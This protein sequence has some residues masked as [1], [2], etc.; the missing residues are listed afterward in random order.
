MKLPNEKDRKGILERVSAKAKILETAV[1]SVVEGYTPA[2]FV[3]GKP[4]LGKT[5]LLTTI[6]DGLC[7]QGWKHHTAYSTP[8]ALFMTLA[9]MPNAVH[10]YE[11]CEPILKTEKTA[12]ILR[13][14]CGAPGDR[15]RLV[16]YETANEK[17]RIKFYGGIIIA[18]N[19]DLSRA[20]GPLQGVASR[21]RPMTWALSMEERVATISLLADQ[22]C[23]RG[24]MALSPKECKEVAV[25]LL[26]W[27]DAG[28]DP[29]S[30]DLRLYCEH[31]L[32][33]FAYCKAKG[34]KNWS[35]VL[36]SK[37]S[38]IA[39]TV[40]ERQHERTGRLEDLAVMIDQGTGSRTAKLADWTAKTGLGKSIYY[41]HLKNAKRGR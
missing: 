7:G 16:T 24:K 3:C 12:S 40:C 13:A 20:N 11:D 18:T 19:A 34:V 26:E 35:D 36:V 27:V 2:L 9:E 1:Q 8:K 5:H 4:G 30:L 37:L 6:L 28:T 38:G 10:L 23:Y 25:A 33:T 17:F 22:G 29:M 21:F 39:E 15:D 31:A 14:A 32:P 41:R